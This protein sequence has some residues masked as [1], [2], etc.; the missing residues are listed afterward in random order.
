[1]GGGYLGLRVG[2]GRG[3]PQVERPPRPDPWRH[4]PLPSRRSRLG[5]PLRLPLMGGGYLG[6]VMGQGWRGPANQ[7][8]DRGYGKPAPRRGLPPKRRSRRMVG[9][10]AW[11]PATIALDG[12]RIP[13]AASGLRT[14]RSAGQ[15]TAASGPLAPC[16]APLTP[17]PAWPPVTTAFHGRRIPGRG[18]G[19]RN[20]QWSLSGHT[21][22]SRGATANQPLDGGCLPRGG[23]EGWRG[24]QTSPSTAATSQEEEQKNG[25]GFP[26][27][28]V[29]RGGWGDR[30]IG[31]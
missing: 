16:A 11:P 26:G 12:G 27:G 30:G 2:E 8:L 6:L 31:G 13:G 3:G 10:P 21:S 18:H 29:E 5:R 7:T 22:L 14:R 19:P 25:G 28:G 20:G 15:A 17:E 4:A 23:A 1:M 9:A 24:R